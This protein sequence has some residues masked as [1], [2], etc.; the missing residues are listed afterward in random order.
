MQESNAIK[1]K[2]EVALSVMD[3]L[4]NAGIEIPFPQRDLRLRAVDP[5]GSRVA[6]AER[7]ARHLSNAADGDQPEP[8]LIIEVP[9][10][11]AGREADNGSRRR[12]ICPSQLRLHFPHRC[13]YS[14]CF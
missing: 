6:R 13:A 4:D 8:S 9:E 10:T 7:F 14:N 11:R 1:V 3:L 2:S 5:A 12:S